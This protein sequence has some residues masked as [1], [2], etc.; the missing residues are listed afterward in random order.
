MGLMNSPCSLAPSP[1]Y[2]LLVN[3]PP[4]RQRTLLLA[5]GT[6]TCFGGGVELVQLRG[7]VQRLRQEK[8]ALRASN[9]AL[10]EHLKL[11]LGATTVAR[12]SVAREAEAL[13]SS[14]VEATQLQRLLFAKILG[15]KSAVENR[16]PAAAPA[17]PAAGAA[18]SDAGGGGVE[19]A[20]TAARSSSWMTWLWGLLP[21]AAAAA[22]ASETPAEAAQTGPEGL[23]PPAPSPPEPVPSRGSS[24]TAALPLADVRRGSRTLPDERR[25]G[26]FP[27]SVV[28][29]GGAPGSEGRGGG[30]SAASGDVRRSSGVRIPDAMSGDARYS[31]ARGPGAPFLSAASPLAHAPPLD[32][33]STPPPQARG[34]TDDYR[35]SS[36]PEGGP[37]RGGGRGGGGRTARRGGERGGGGAHDAGALALLYG[38]GSS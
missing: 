31:P 35:L 12:T 32:A 37:Q 27:G 9:Q 38:P 14:R 16:L 1:T 24:S 33:V 23:S 30:G 34:R 26:H 36:A 21:G 6:V 11:A 28:L 17:P 25:A 19:P 10:A 20:A 22:A 29:R 15:E 5:P 2:P 7:E 18:A 3:F 8:E 4:P 13:A